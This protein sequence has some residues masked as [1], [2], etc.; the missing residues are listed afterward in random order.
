[1]AQGGGVVGE[2]GLLGRNGVTDTLIQ[3]K[4]QSTD[5]KR[6]TG[7]GRENEARLNAAQRAVFDKQAF[8]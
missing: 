2:R 1:M 4:D 5:G 7:W 8:A 3:C 6:I